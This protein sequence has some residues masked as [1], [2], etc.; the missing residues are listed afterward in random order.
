MSKDSKIITGK[1]RVGRNLLAGVLDLTNSQP[2]I[3][4]HYYGR[5]KGKLFT[6]EIRKV[7]T[8]DSS[9]DQVTLL[10]LRLVGDSLRTNSNYREYRYIIDKV[11]IG[12]IA[13]RKEKI[14]KSASFHLKDLHKDFFVPL[15]NDHK[16]LENGN[17]QINLELVSNQILVNSKEYD[18]IV[19]Y[20]TRDLSYSSGS[21]T[22]GPYA[23]IELVFH[24]VEKLDTIVK[25]VQEVSELFIFLTS[26]YRTPKSIHVYIEGEKLPLKL[27]E[28][29]KRSDDY[30]ND[31]VFPIFNLVK[32][33]DL[34]K[35]ISAKWIEVF[36]SKS[37]NFRLFSSDLTQKNHYLD[38][39]YFNIMALIDNL[40]TERYGV[41]L[42]K[43]DYDQLP[44]QYI[45]ERIA[46][47]KKHSSFK[48]RFLRY[49]H[50]TNYELHGKLSSFT[51]NMNIQHSADYDE[52][53]A[54]ILIKLRDDIA[55]GKARRNL[56]HM[57]EAYLVAK[58]IALRILLEELGLT[59]VE[60]N[61]IINAMHVNYYAN[62]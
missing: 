55:H 51:S 14:F 35:K 23:Y 62:L 15:K 42:K 6:Q 52:S 16:I 39:T 58:F 43:S 47:K 44:Y 34:L 30:L 1:W 20:G 7:T 4:L 31:T 54:D 24:K 9:Q 10:N 57:Y 3:T 27:I 59:S 36:E 25:S 60:C 56:I 40:L 33:E 8:K 45:K 2:S 17:I 48:D 32:D 18:I 21:E 49:I 61:K 50:S 53:V 13:S 5:T 46:E 41:K 12:Q 11:L 38:N 26:K 22:F 19:H 28:H 37:L 29:Q